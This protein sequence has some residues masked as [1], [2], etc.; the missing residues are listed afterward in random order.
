MKVCVSR[1]MLERAKASD[2]N[3]GRTDSVSAKAALV[4][5]FARLLKAALST[6]F[7]STPT[8]PTPS[9]YLQAQVLL[10]SPSGFANP[11]E[12][13]QVPDTRPPRGQRD[14]VLTRR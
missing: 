12:L 9:M 11:V 10:F 6:D 3:D 1:N 2:G 4:L 5:N 8:M 14:S 7:L 13:R